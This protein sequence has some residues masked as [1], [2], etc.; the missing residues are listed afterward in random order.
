MT[1]AAPQGPPAAAAGSVVAGLQALPSYER[2]DALT[3][4]VS[5]HVARILGI[6]ADG[7]L[8]VD[9]GLFEMGMD[10]LMSV[11]LKSSLERAFGA[12]LPST[13]TFNY[14]S[15]R[16][17]SQFL[18]TDILMSGE[19]AAGTDPASPPGSLVEPPT[20]A[21]AAAEDLDDL[22]EDELEAMLASRLGGAR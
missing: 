12:P 1:S 19:P 14:P 16:A 8:D 10:S 22:S 3:V 11:E 13:L 17:L 9:R 6:E 4:H 18:W 7:S 5:A 15:V 2:R 20:E 21:R